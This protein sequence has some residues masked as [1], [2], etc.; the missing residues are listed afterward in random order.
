MAP[1]R[2]VFDRISDGIGWRTDT[3]VMATTRPQPAACMSGTAAWHMATV[4]SRLRWRA[5]S[6][7]S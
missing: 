5:F 6:K 4:D 3:D 2:A 7:S 1:A